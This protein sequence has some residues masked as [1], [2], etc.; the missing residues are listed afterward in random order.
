MGFGLHAGWAIEGAVGS[1]EKI[2]ATYLSPHVNMAARL[3]TSSR[4][5]GVPLLV[6]QSVFELFS[7]RVQKYCRKLDVVTVKGSEFPIPIYTYDC[8]QDQTFIPLPLAAELRKRNSM[9]QS[10]RPLAAGSAGNEDPGA[11]PDSAEDQPMINP[12]VGVDCNGQAVRGI[13]KLPDDDATDVFAD[14][15]DLRMLR[16]HISDEFRS[17]F[18]KGVNTYLEG[19]WSEARGLLQQCDDMMKKIPSLDG[20]GPSKTLLRYMEN[21]NWTAPDDW[22]GFRPLTSK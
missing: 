18:E 15:C 10:S 5:Y 22:G 12:S 21:L 20:D 3:E 16:A 1:L 9:Y 4:Q 19:K 6:S 17:L 2:D 7:D 11:A 14:D 8:L 13:F